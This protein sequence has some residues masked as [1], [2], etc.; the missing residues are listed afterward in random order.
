[1]GLSV[2][3]LVKKLSLSLLVSVS[4]LQMQRK[5]RKRTGPL[6]IAFS[7]CNP[8]SVRGSD[9]V[10]DRAWCRDSSPMQSK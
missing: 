7:L 6:R 8:E 9:E 4:A 1:M 2:G 3:I 10:A 5:D